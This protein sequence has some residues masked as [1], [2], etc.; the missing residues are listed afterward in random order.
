METYKAKKVKKMEDY[1]VPV[2]GVTKSP[3]QAVT[4]TPKK[5]VPKPI[6]E[7][8]SRIHEAAVTVPVDG[9][10][11][12]SVPARKDWKEVSRDITIEKLFYKD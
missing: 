6:T 7:V 4:K 5:E 12:K 9:V 2:Q 1:R 3:I 11:I 8:S 10:P